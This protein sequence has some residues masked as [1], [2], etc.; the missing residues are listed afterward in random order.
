LTVSSMASLMAMPRLP[1][2]A[3]SSAEHLAAVFG[4]VA[5]AGM[6]RRAPG[7]HE[8]PAI[9]LVLVAHLDHVN[10]AFQAEQF[11]R[12]RQR[13][14]P[15]ARA[16]FGGEPLGAGDLV[17]IRLGDGGVDLVAAGGLTPSYL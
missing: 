11:A 8:H 13:R 7:V 16:G 4:L 17:E 12:Q 10:I 2:N 3:G 14:T 9:R 6:H 1:G 15:L 5:R